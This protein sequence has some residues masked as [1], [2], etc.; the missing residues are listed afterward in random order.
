MR[1][2]SLFLIA[3]CFACGGSADEPGEVAATTGIGGED[4][5]PATFEWG[6]PIGDDLRVG[7]QPS[8]GDLEAAAA[9]GVRTVISLRTEGEA[10]SE[11]ERETTERV[12]LRFVSIPIAGPGD[13]TEAN[14]RALDEALDG[15]GPA[16]LHCASGNRVGALLGLRA[17]L[18]EGA[19][20]DEA[21]SL[22]AEAGMTR[23]GPALR[24]KLSELCADEPGRCPSE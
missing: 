14:A 7:G 8:A 15:S 24:A 16:I 4:T 13:L 23:L 9:A 10:G 18:V 5:R 21:M 12:G 11:G 17:Y 22:A 3:L 19:T 2:A 20:G 1:A 6:T